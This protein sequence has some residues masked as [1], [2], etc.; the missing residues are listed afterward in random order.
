MGATPCS[1]RKVSQNPPN[2]KNSYNHNFVGRF[3]D[4]DQVYDVD[5]EEGTMFQ[6]LVCED[7]FHEKCIGEGRVP[8]QD[9]F[10]AFVCQVCVGKNEWLG[11]YVGNK[12]AFM[13]TLETYSEIKV[14]VEATNEALA[15][16]VESIESNPMPSIAEPGRAA[17][18]EPPDAPSPSNVPTTGVKRSLSTDPETSSLPPKR[19]KSE[20]EETPVTCKWASLPRTPPLPFALFLKEAFRDSLCRCLDCET[21]RLRTLP[22]ISHEEETYE[23]DEDNSDTGLSS[24]FLSAAG[25]NT[26]DS[27]L[28]AG[29]RALSSLPRTQALDGIVAYQALS[30][31]LKTFF[32]G[33]AETGRVV[34]EADVRGFFAEMQNRAPSDVAS[35]MVPDARK[36][37]SAK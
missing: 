23:P 29:T 16:T 19:V 11:R 28:E 3:C 37:E 5:A 26:L 10:D 22:M 34:S 8:D 32:Q 12:T 2:D 17:S 6:C 15:S 31:K 36:E 1:L 7:W 20:S 9:D 27:I 25:F 13:S 24:P 33:F 14:D 30:T 4:C 35:Q 21:T 18:T